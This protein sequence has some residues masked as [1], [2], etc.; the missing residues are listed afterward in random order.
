MCVW[1]RRKPLCEEMCELILTAIGL[2]RAVLAVHGL[3]A[4]PRQWD[5]LSAAVAALELIRLANVRLYKSNSNIAPQIHGIEIRQ[6][7]SDYYYGN[8]VIRQGPY[9]NRRTHSLVEKGDQQPPVRPISPTQNT[10]TW[11]NI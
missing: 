8:Y 6:L 1:K 5:T 11:N 10:A 7:R 3:I 9:A 4:H 2:I